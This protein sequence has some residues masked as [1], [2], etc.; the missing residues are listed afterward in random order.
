MYK[1][2]L[3]G[4]KFYGFHGVLPE[5]RKLGQYFVIDLEL[6]FTLE[7]VSINDDLFQ[8]IDYTKVYSLVKQQVL[9]RKVKLLETLALNILREIFLN[10]PVEKIYIK[11]IKP[12]P[13]ID[14]FLAYVGVEF[15][16]N[17]QDF[18]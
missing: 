9:G 18:C 7:K 13:P 4:M 6:Y 12:K 5:E 3:K 14:G 1:I 8:T 10:F 15:L 2:L 16:R 11:V 17:R